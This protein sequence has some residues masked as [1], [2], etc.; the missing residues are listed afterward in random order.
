MERTLLLHDAME[1]PPR[2]VDEGGSSAAGASASGHA[3]AQ[4]KVEYPSAD[5]YKE[6]SPSCALIT[7]C[8][9]GGH[10]SG[11]RLRALSQMTGHSRTWSW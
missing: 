7:R 6:M 4:D 9:D 8:V 3:D 1:E 5:G 11:S 2:Y 10:G